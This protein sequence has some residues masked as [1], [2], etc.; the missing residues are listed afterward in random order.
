MGSRVDC[1]IGFSRHVYNE[2]IETLAKNMEII[3]NQ[4]TKSD[5]QH[6][7]KF[8]SDKNKKEGVDK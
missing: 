3:K 6:F 1:V 5:K 4:L 7:E 8:E 2:V